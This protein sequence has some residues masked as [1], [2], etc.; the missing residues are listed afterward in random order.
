MSPRVGRVDE[1]ADCDSDVKAIKE[2]ENLKAQAQSSNS[3]LSDEEWDCE[4]VEYSTVP[5]QAGGPFWSILNR[6]FIRMPP[7]LPRRHFHLFPRDRLHR[8]KQPLGSFWVELGGC[9]GCKADDLTVV[10]CL[11]LT[12]SEVGIPKRLFEEY[13]PILG[14]AHGLGC[15]GVFQAL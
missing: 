1:Y 9:M 2:W 4:Y 15:L 13:L 3:T 8:G 7:R 6:I 12:T 14:P 11:L 10:E 5:D